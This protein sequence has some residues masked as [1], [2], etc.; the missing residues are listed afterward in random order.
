MRKT[1]II[2]MTL[3]GGLAA[4]GPALEGNGQAGG[5][6]RAVQVWPD[7]DGARMTD[8][9]EAYCGQ[10]GRSA[11]VASEDLSWVWLDDVAFDCIN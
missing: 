7:S 11:H 6:I 2:A 9:A 5:T 10:F 8:M 4:C 3:L 1:A